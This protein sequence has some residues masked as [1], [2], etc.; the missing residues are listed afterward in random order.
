MLKHRGLI[1]VVLA[2]FVMPAAMAQQSDCPAL[3]SD[4]GLHWE[5][6]RADD[7]IFC[8]AL[9]DDQSELFSVSISSDSPFNPARR[10][11]GEKAVING[12]EVY[13]Y[14]TEIATRPDLQARETSIALSNGRVAYFNV[15]SASEDGLR[16]AFDLIAK[17]GF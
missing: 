10:N 1:G 13:W 3:G 6:A 17:L 8:R 4:S 12:Q 9:T 2:T 16:Q 14:R 7:L 11:R 5:V 15:Q